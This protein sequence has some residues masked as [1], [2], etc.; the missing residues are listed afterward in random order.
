MVMGL[1]H[2]VWL[3]LIWLRWRV[4]AWIWLVPDSIERWAWNAH[5]ISEAEWYG[6]PNPKYEDVFFEETG[7]DLG[8]GVSCCGMLARPGTG[9]EKARPG[10]GVAKR[11]SA[12]ASRAIDGT[13]PTILVRTPYGSNQRSVARLYAERGFNYVILD[14]RGRFQTGGDFIPVHDEIDD[15]ATVIKWA[16]QQ[17]WFDG[18][19][20]TH[21]MSYLGMTSWAMIGA[22][23]PALKV[24]VPVLCAASIHP[25]AFPAPRAIA[26]ELITQWTWLTHAMHAAPATAGMALLE[27]MTRIK[28]WG[29]RKMISATAR[30]CNTLPMTGLDVA[31][32]VGKVGYIQE[33]I[34]NMEVDSAFWK[35]RNHLADLRPVSA[36]GTGGP[37]P[38]SLSLIAAW[39]DFFLEQQ[40]RDFQAARATAEH[41]T[42]T[43]FWAHHW[44]LFKLYRPMVRCIMQAYYRHLF[45][46]HFC[47]RTASVEN[48]NPPPAVRLELGGGGG[49]RGY[50]SWP[51][52][53][54]S[55]LT[56]FLGAGGARHHSSQGS[57]AAGA[58]AGEE[59]VWSYVY[60]ASDPTPSIG[61]PSFNG[62]NA[63][64]KLMRPLEWRKDVLTFDLTPPLTEDVVVVGE[65]LPPPLSP[66]F[67]LRYLHTKLSFQSFT[68]RMQMTNPAVLFRGYSDYLARTHRWARFLCEERG[69]MAGDGEHVVL[70]R[71]PDS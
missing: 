37:L 2:V 32:G 70:I 24:G 64:V 27:C 17:P 25:I 3:N 42:L 65:V 12:S 35:T 34:R 15:G 9:V 28:I 21:G 69:E 61:G 22:R 39:H 4:L 10:T 40:L 23:D 45:A 7:C 19:I 66:H 26:L 71:P 62:F 63:G 44:D 11:G 43:V 36:G 1:L 51:P 8:E 54:S 49:W 16:K 57:A 14:T 68:N 56:L 5:R 18:S 60:D 47:G 55:P 50:S 33:G 59:E 48:P 38:C 30:A 13:R 58:A 20:G 31:L 52:E 53:E 6:I 41:A 29:G 67:L 46:L